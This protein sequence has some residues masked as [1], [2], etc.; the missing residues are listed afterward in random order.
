MGLRLMAIVAAFPLT[1]VMVGMVFS[2]LSALRCEWR[3][4][5]KG[6]RSADKK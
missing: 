4:E 3:Y 1:I 6:G 2:L 5:L